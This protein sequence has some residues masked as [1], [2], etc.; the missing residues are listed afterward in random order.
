MTR[1]RTYQ[2]TGSAGEVKQGRKVLWADETMAVNENWSWTKWYVLWRGRMLYGLSIFHRNHVCH[3]YDRKNY[4]VKKLKK[5]FL[6]EKCRTTSPTQF[7]VAVN[8]RPDATYFFDM[9]PCSFPSAFQFIWNDG[10]CA[11]SSVIAD[12]RSQK[13]KRQVE[14][15]EDQCRAYQQKRRLH[16]QRTQLIVFL[17]SFH[18]KNYANCICT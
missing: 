16:L 3:Y 17:V 5:Q 1:R 18:K 9:I 6:W 8:F 15:F 13:S 11:R 7:I 4:I 14:T 2:W 10:G 12:E